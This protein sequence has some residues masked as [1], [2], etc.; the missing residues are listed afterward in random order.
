M[1]EL[2]VAVRARVPNNVTMEE[3]REYV[4]DAVASWRGSLRPP[5]SYDD[6]DPG[7]P[8]WGLD[9]DSVRVTRL[10][11]RKNDDKT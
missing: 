8:L 6:D 4:L 11:K 5:Y 9:P 2:V 3:F 10:Y 1:K 7:D